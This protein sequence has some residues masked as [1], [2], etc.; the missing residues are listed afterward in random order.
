MKNT[1]KNKTTNFPQKIIKLLLS[2]GKM[3]VSLL[4]KQLYILYNLSTELN[5]KIELAFT[6]ARAFQIVLNI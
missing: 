2:T 1:Y 3:T 5:Q 4:K 6:I